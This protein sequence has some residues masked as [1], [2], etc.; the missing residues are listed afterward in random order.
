MEVEV[1]K[2]FYTVKTSETKGICIPT[3][4][5]FDIEDSIRHDEKQIQ[6]LCG[7]I[8]AR[9]ESIGAKRFLQEYNENTSYRINQFR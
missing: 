9:R 2:K 7:M 8:R 4:K 5:D 3:R 6:D 1:G